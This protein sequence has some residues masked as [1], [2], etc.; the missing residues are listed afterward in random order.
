MVADLKERE[1]LF[2][3]GVGEA[4][5][6]GGGIISEWRVLGIEEPLPGGDVAGDV[7][8]WMAGFVDRHREGSLE[9]GSE[10]TR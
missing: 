7:E 1:G 5:D 4:L 8:M 6:F 3:C 10:V 2:C 9:S